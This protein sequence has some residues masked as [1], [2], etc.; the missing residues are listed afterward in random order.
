MQLPPIVFLSSSSAYLPSSSM[1]VRSIS[2]I[3]VL[4][5]FVTQGIP[6]LD[7]HN[8]HPP[9]TLIQPSSATPPAC[10]YHN[11][12]KSL[13][14]SRPI[15]APAKRATSQVP[16]RLLSDGKAQGV[17]R[18]TALLELCSACCGEA[19]TQDATL[20]PIFDSIRHPRSEITTNVTSMWR[21]VCRLFLSFSLLV[22]FFV[23]FS[24]LCNAFLRPR[25][26]LTCRTLP[27]S[28]VSFIH[29]YCSITLLLPISKVYLQATT[30]S[31]VH[32]FPFAILCHSIPV[33]LFPFCLST[34]PRRIYIARHRLASR[35]SRHHVRPSLYSPVSALSSYISAIPLLL[36]SIFP[37]AHCIC[38]HRRPCRRTL[39]HS[40]SAT[41][42]LS[43]DENLA[44]LYLL[45]LQAANMSGGAYYQTATQQMFRP[46]KA[47]HWE[48]FREIITDLYQ[49]NTLS[50]VIEEMKA[51]HLFSATYVP[52]PLLHLRPL[53][54]KRFVLTLVLTP[55]PDQNS[56][57]QDSRSGASP[58]STSR[59]RSTSICSPST[60]KTTT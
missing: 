48:P 1:Y 50:F 5:C 25:H 53:Y 28:P 19:H 32:E 41:V 30:S 8:P 7:S 13:P 57:R 52:C 60:S 54:I 34:K 16:L 38:Q 58:P 4:V 17:S 21:L 10:L 59:P 2:L 47:E 40:S 46:T 37:S 6:A 11:W 45:Q 15:L 20:L 33:Q 49:E 9:P 18:C 31:R 14:P 12:T 24:L 26:G 43:M 35:P 22:S 42:P 27:S 29:I 55:P 39:A 3:P 23:L 36:F 51:V 56:T 44:L